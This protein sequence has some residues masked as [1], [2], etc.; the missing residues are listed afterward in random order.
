[1]TCQESFD[2]ILD[3][4][5]GELSPAE[6][7]A[8]EKHVAEC[9]ECAREAAALRHVIKSVV[10]PAFVPEEQYFDNFYNSVR[11]RIAREMPPETWL[12]RLKSLVFGAGGWRRPVFAA[13]ALSL[14]VVGVLAGTGT[15]QQWLGG[16]P[17]VN[18][19]GVGRIKAITNTQ[20]VQP[21]IASE[22]GRLN[23]EE[24]ETLR[25]QIV[26]RLMPEGASL[27]GF[28]PNPVVASPT[29]SD[30]SDHEAVHLVDMVQQQAPSWSF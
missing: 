12:D 30:L 24:I 21:Q 8:V 15:L 27:T 9:A 6:A 14:L 20:D 22:I 11:D 23:P 13:V 25:G 1:M 10:E 2:K 4:I 18:V 19:A 16:E 29:Y 7:D 17:Q 3:W 5:E 28:E 26:E